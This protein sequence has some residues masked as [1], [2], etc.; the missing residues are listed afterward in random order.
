MK[1]NA[2]TKHATESFD[3]CVV[4]LGYV[5]LPTASILATKGKKVI[6]VD[7]IPSVVDGVNRGESHFNEQD[8]DLLLRAAVHSGN[9]VARMAPAPADVYMVAVPTPFKDAEDGRRVPDLSMVESGIKSI[10]GLLKPGDVVILESTSPVGTTEALQHWVAESRK[11]L[12]LEDLQQTVHYAHCPERILPGQLMKELIANDRVCGGLTSVAASKAADVYRQFCTGEIHLTDART[13]ELSKLA[14]NA[15][16]DVNIAFANELSLV[17][18]R[19]RINVWNVIELA[20]R[21]PRVRI[22][23]PGPG[24]GGHCIAVDPWFIIA[25]APDVCPLMTAAR[26]VNDEKPRYVFDQIRR[27]AD[28]FKQP[29]IAC[30][31]LMFKADVDDMRES[32]AFEVVKLLAEAKIANLL[33]V[34][35]RLE[36]LPPAFASDRTCRLASLDEAIAEAD[37]VAVLVDHAEF[38]RARPLGIERKVLIDTRGIWSA[39]S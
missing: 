18:D 7:I 6:G 23:R 15:Y 19:L 8:L 37:I 26:H 17:C 28:R 38:R 34:E 33:I 3:V 31:G 14:E 16:R 12:G 36:E 35:P 9:L 29:V 22:L 13:A 2:P 32:P 27:S 5:G 20:N 11:A 39:N 21:H 30:L 4:G 24:V 10:A 1:K 25:S